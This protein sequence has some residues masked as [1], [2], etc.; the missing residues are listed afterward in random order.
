MT[1]CSSWAHVLVATVVFL[2][3]FFPQHNTSTYE[4]LRAPTSTTYATSTT[5][6]TSTSTSTSKSSKRSCEDSEVNGK[7][8]RAGSVLSIDVIILLSIRA[9]YWV[10]R[11]IGLSGKG[12]LRYDR[13]VP[14]CRKIVTTSSPQPAPFHTLLAC[15][16]HVASR[17][18]LPLKRRYILV[19]ALVS[20]DNLL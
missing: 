19:L 8:K 17:R 10:K 7:K 20:H 6:R 14:S 2:A 3:H 15:Q 18:V 1:N 12:F 16:P 9:L 5:Q 13:V 11:W 4:H